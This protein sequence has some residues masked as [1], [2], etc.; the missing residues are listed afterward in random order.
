[1]NAH[2]DSQCS[3][4]SSVSVLEEENSG[5]VYSV[6]VDISLIFIAQKDKNEIVKCKTHPDPATQLWLFA[7]TC[8]DCI[9]ML[10]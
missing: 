4:L 1:M 10:S 9:R 8:T 2:F 7:S 6:D 5:E 3:Q